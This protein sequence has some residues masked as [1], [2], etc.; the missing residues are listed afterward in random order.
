MS[1]PIVLTD[2]QRRQLARLIAALEQ[3]T[4]GELKIVIEPFCDGDPLQC[5]QKHFFRLGLQ[6]TRHRTGV[7]VYLAY[8]SRQFALLGD[9]GLHRHLPPD[10]WNALRD[11][12]IPLLQQKSVYEALQHALNRCGAELARFF[13]ATTPNINE[14][15]DAVEGH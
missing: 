7:L 14:L 6:H 10:F 3:Q 5:A 12:L 9:E 4:T 1:E 8:V 11:E 13:P 2:D 15:S